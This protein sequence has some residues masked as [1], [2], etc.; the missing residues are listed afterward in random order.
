MS[1]VVCVVSTQKF[2]TNLFPCFKRSP[3]LCVVP[4]LF[5][6]VPSI[7]QLEAVEA[8]AG[9][10]VCD[11]VCVYVHMCDIFLTHA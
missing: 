9:A 5:N 3:P 11:C 6:L 2:A 10:C 8:S 7:I 1:G 4:F